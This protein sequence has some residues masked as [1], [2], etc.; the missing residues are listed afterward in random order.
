[1]GDK[2]GAKEDNEFHPHPASSTTNIHYKKTLQKT[3]SV[4]GDARRDRLFV[5]TRGGT[6]Q[7]T[8]RAS[9]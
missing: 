1:L 7:T 4:V 9:L 2:E 3:D 5:A 6:I 8:T